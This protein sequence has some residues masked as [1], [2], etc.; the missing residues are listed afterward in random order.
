M[1]TIPSADTRFSAR[2]SAVVVIAASAVQILTLPVVVGAV[3]V[4]AETFSVETRTAAMLSGLS[5]ALVAGVVGVVARRTTDDTTGPL[6]LTTVVTCVLTSTG[7]ITGV[8]LFAV[9]GWMAV[10]AMLVTSADVVSR[11]VAAPSP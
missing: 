11:A 3:R 2:L 1:S 4:P 6:A 7:L 8:A 9:A 10:P 5:F